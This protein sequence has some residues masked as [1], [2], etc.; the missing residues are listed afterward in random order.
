M[1]HIC[2]PH[3]CAVGWTDAE[4]EHLGQEL[5][6][7]LIYLVR[8]AEQCHIDLPAAVLDKFKLNA[9]KYPPVPEESKLRYSRQEED[10]RQ[11]TQGDSKEEDSRSASEMWQTVSINTS[12]HMYDNIIHAT[13]TLIPAGS[14]VNT[15]ITQWNV[16]LWRLFRKKN[17]NF[18]MSIYEHVPCSCPCS[19]CRLP[20][21]TQIEK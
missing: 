12:M 4:R 14:I 1:L 5:S 19:W 18:V 3:T 7:V 9:V 13:A 8:L 17:Q 21:N 2:Q 11:E 16:Y 10:S 15:P 20:H 6:D